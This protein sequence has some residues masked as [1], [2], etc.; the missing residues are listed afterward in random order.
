MTQIYPSNGNV[1]SNITYC[2]SAF[3]IDYRYTDEISVS[4]YNIT[5]GMH[6]PSTLQFGMQKSGI[7]ELKEGSDTNC[8]HDGKY[9]WSKLN[10]MH[11]CVCTYDYNDPYNGYTISGYS[12][13]VCK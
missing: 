2:P 13:D 3:I 11:L 5:K 12:I 7:C 10:P 8:S 9:C 4:D 6:V 1:G